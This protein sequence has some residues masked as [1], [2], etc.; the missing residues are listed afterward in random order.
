MPTA[1]GL[2]ASCSNLAATTVCTQGAYHVCHQEQ[3]ALSIIP[4]SSE[5]T[6]PERSDSRVRMRFVAAPGFPASS[7]LLSWAKSELCRLHYV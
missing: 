2:E 5:E 6:R 1:M 4:R 3:V 7:T